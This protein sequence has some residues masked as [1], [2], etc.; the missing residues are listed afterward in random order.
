MLKIRH[1][2]TGVRL[3]KKA[4]DS[5][6]RMEKP[7]CSLRVHYDLNEFKNRIILCPCRCLGNK[8]KYLD[9]KRYLL[10]KRLEM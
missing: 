10:E 9:D 8:R 5:V 1:E 4:N 6:F 7:G 3:F 2:V